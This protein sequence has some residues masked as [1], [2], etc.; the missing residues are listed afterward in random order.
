M[1][2]ATVDRTTEERAPAASPVRVWIG[3]VRVGTIAMVVFAILLQVVARAIIPPVFVIGLVFLGVTPFLRGE[4]RG[5][6]LGA[7]IFGAAAYVG[8]L[9]II[10]DDLSHPES[11]PSFIAQL[12]STIALGLV[13]VGGVAAWFRRS[14]RLL[15]PLALAAAGVFVAGTFASVAIAADT[16]SVAA[17]PGDVPV[18]AERLMWAPEE[19]VIDAATTGIWIDNEDGFRHTFTIPELGIDVEVPA[20]K[21]RRVDIDAPPG[22]YEIICEV[23]GHDSMTGTLIVS[24]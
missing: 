15:R 7:A 9:P 5:L 24:S 18:T 16:D 2:T 12:L 10:I 3:L 20:L 17:L 11:A 19:V 14:T 23:P 21:A 13:V 8:N 6:A 1:A 4:R 22:T